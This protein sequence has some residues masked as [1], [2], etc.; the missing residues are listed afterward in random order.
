MAEESAS[1]PK[2]A[3][4]VQGQSTEVND[5]FSDSIS[6]PSVD[7]EMSPGVARVAAINRN[8]TRAD[9][10]GVFIG[11]FLIAY[12]YGL[13][14]TIRYTYQVCY[15]PIGASLGRPAYI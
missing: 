14:G 11:V 10:I 3:A 4:G 12:A 7:N 9:R 15:L 5:E 6:G 2:I 13:D 8:M 1:N